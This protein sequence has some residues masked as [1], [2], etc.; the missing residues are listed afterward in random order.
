MSNRDVL[1]HVSRDKER[2]PAAITVLMMASVALSEATTLYKN[3][4]CTP[5][6]LKDTCYLSQEFYHA[7][8]ATLNCSTARLFASCQYACGSVSGGHACC[9]RLPGDP[10]VQNFYPGGGYKCTPPAPKSPTARVNPCCE[11]GGAVCGTYKHIPS[12]CL[13]PGPFGSCFPKYEPIT[14][15]LQFTRCCDNG[16]CVAGKCHACATTGKKCDPK[17]KES[18]CCRYFRCDEK[19]KRCVKCVPPNIQCTPNVDVCC[20]GVCSTRDPKTDESFAAAECRSS[21]G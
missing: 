9:Q 6:S 21:S 2:M 12:C 13:P 5:G 3:S 17:A 18:S 15:F 20:R 1:I 14:D 7:Q 10:S 4:A 19:S 16:R 11:D 8:G